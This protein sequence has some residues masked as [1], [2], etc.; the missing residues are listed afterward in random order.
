MQT[1]QTLYK[2]ILE[3]NDHRGFTLI[4]VLLA[5]T[6]FSSA[7]LLLTQSWGHN[8]SVLRSTQKR[9]EIAQLLEQKA[10]EVL[11]EYDEK[12]LDSIPEEKEDNFGT[13]YPGYKWKLESRPL[14]IPLAQLF[15]GGENQEADPIMTTMVSTLSEY[16]KKAIKEARVTVSYTGS[17]NPISVSV[18]IYFVDFKQEL[19]LG[20]G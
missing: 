6:I 13:E 16:F 2:S 7:V 11:M 5:I 15:V 10:A 17:K 20:G 12:P 18:T 9:V 8:Y 14:E 1:N 3:K 4:E 19:S